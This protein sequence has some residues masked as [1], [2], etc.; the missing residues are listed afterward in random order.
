[1]KPRIRKGTAHALDA[2]GGTFNDPY[3]QQQLKIMH[4]TGMKNKAQ[5]EIY[6]GDV[7]CA[8][9]GNDVFIGIV[10]YLDEEGCYDL[11][12]GFKTDGDENQGGRLFSF[13][14]ITVIGNIYE[15]PELL[16]DNRASCAEGAAQK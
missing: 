5:K 7:V 3:S 15:N 9:R 8:K 6:E 1:M 4:Y 11:D 2:V 10:R 12:C 13:T 14:S 16:N